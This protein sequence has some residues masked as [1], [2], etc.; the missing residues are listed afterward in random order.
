MTFPALRVSTR[1]A[2]LSAALT[3]GA[4]AAFSAAANADGAARLATPNATYEGAGVDGSGLMTLSI[5]SLGKLGSYTTEWHRTVCGI[6]DFALSY[7]AGTGEGLAIDA[8]GHVEERYTITYKS[9]GKRFIVRAVDAVELTT[10]TGTDGVPHETVS[11]RE[12]VRVRPARRGAPWCAGRHTKT[13]QGVPV[14]VTP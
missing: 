12:R 4:A 10:T 11:L 3:L 6:P 2:T 8:T 13:F 5:N 14:T 9:A 7:N 1:T